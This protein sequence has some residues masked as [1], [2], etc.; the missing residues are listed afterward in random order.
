MES[1]I[2][3]LNA[4]SSSLKFALYRMQ[5]AAEE[6]IFSGAAEE[7]GASEGR[8]WLRGAGDRVLAQSHERFASHGEAVTATFTA[9]AEQGVRD[10]DAVGH[11]IVHGGPFFT[12]PTRVDEQVRKRLQEVIPFAPLHL[13]F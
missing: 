10:P 5:G 7:I 9:L 13:P 6:R 12:S 2:L 8:F 3:S 1:T 11:R 4:G